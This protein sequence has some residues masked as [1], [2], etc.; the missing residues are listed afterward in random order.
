MSGR[1]PTRRGARHP[2]RL[3]GVSGPLV[4]RRRRGRGRQLAEG[5]ALL[6]SAFVFTTPSGGPL[7]ARTVL[8]RFG[9]LLDLAELRHVRFHHL[10]HSAAS[11]MLIQGVQMRVVMEVLGHSQLST[12]SDTYSHVVPELQREAAARMDALLS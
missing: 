12:T 3:V 1:L 2:E 6:P 9:D 7:E 5:R 10:R 4:E 11:L 8:R